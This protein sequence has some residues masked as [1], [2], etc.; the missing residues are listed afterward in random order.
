MEC[1]KESLNYY[2]V[3]KKFIFTL[4][5]RVRKSR[6]ISSGASLSYALG[7]QNDKHYR[8]T[9]LVQ[10]IGEI[11]KVAHVFLARWATKMTNIRDT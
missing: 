10:D 4:R 1:F 6:D 3:F 7:L 2:F 9:S 11:L 8:D 5:R